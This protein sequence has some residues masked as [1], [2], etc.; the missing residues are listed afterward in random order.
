MLI[1]TKNHRRKLFEM[2]HSLT[3]PLLH[4]TDVSLFYLVLTKS[5][6]VTNGWILKYISFCCRYKHKQIVLFI[7][8]YMFFI[9]FFIILYTILYILYMF[10]T[11][12]MASS[13]KDPDIFCYI[14]G[15]FTL[16]DDR[17]NITKFVKKAYLAYFLLCFSYRLLMWMSH[18]CNKKCPDHCSI[19]FV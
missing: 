14:Y 17:R 4:P 9:I 11:C 3:P 5:F 6:T 2:K 19:F 7:I 16:K 18:R 1:V 15:S 10:C 13:S 12:Y 8:L